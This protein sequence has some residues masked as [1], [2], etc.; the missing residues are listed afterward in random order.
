M[1]EGAIDE[2]EA[3][4]LLILSSDDLKEHI[5]SFSKLDESYMKASEELERQKD[6]N[7]KLQ[8]ELHNKDIQN[9][10]IKMRINGVFYLIGIFVVYYLGVLYILIMANDFW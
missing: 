8:N 2:T 4:R 1:A 6:A 5:E 10:I 7:I 9:K 3:E